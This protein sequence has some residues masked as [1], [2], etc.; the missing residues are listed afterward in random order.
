[1]SSIQNDIFVII[2]YFKNFEVLDLA[3]IS[4]F[5]ASLEIVIGIIFAPLIHERRDG[6]EWKRG[7]HTHPMNQS[8]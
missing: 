7:T 2:T 5:L 8:I 6:R 4:T 3:L 1:M